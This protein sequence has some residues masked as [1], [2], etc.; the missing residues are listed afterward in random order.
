MSYRAITI[1]QMLSSGGRGEW[2]SDM[3]RFF[4]SHQC[5]PIFAHFSYYNILCILALPRCMSLLLTKIDDTDT[6]RDG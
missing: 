3:A 1:S 5:K 4:D 2:V 6:E